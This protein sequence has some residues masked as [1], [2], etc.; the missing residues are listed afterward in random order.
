MTDRPLAL[1]KMSGLAEL[2]RALNNGKHINRVSEP[3]LW[4]ELEREQDAYQALFSALGYELRVD[5]RGFAWIHTDE[6]N[7][8][9]SNQS[10]QLALLFMLIFDTQADAGRPLGRFEDWVID[11]DLLQTA[12]EQH[13]ELL[14]A[15][16]L[17][18]DSLFGL[19]ETV[20]HHSITSPL[21][22]A[23]SRSAVA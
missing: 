14:L 12:F 16:E 4:V 10:R 20:L 1:N 3:V 2:F 15:E 7:A 23:S 6:A 18:V 19:L 22:K 11:R 9:L 5:G 13:Q 17:T 21:S 8:N